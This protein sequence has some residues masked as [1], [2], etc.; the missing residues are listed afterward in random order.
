M[1][2]LIITFASIG[3]EGGISIATA[4]FTTQRNCVDAGKSAEKNVDDIASNVR[5]I[6][7]E[8]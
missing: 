3:M 2:I 5:F 7:S 1:W 6:C 8:K 4:E